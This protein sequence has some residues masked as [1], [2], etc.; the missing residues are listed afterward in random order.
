MSLLT[1]GAV[2]PAVRL[3]LAT[4]ND[5]GISWPSTIYSGYIVLHRDPTEPAP[6]DLAV[7]EAHSFVI[8]DALAATRP[9]KQP[10]LIE[11]SVRAVR[12]QPEP[13]PLHVGAYDASID[14]VPDPARG[15][16]LWP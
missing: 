6:A 10:V 13:G 4:L 12:T 15:E 3:R 14:F 16:K 9:P 1:V 5:Q 7:T 2:V 11:L 8:P